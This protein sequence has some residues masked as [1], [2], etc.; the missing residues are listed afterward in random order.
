[1]EGQ[2]KNTILIK[3]KMQIV[4]PAPVAQ[5]IMTMRAV[6]SP[7]VIQT[8]S[9]SQ[10]YGLCK[11]YG[12]SARKWLREFGFLLPE[13]YR[14]RLY[15]KYRCTSIHMFAA[16]LAGMNYD[17][18]NRIL[19]LSEKLKDMPL[20]WQ[21]F[22]RFGWTKLAVVANVAHGE[23]EKFWLDKLRKMPKAA[24]IEYVRQ[25][26]NINNKNSDEIGPKS[27]LF[28]LVPCEK[29]ESEI[30]GLNK[31]QSVGT[32][33]LGNEFTDGNVAANV[34][35][36]MQRSEAV[37]F[38]G[39]TVQPFFKKLKFRVDPETEFEF[40]KFKQKMEKERKVELT[41]GETLK[42]LLKKVKELESEKFETQAMETT[43]IS[44][45]NK[46]LQNNNAKTEI[47]KPADLVKDPKSFHKTKP[48]RHI[49]NAQKRL[50]LN[51]YNGKCAFPSC[52]EPYFELHHPDRFSTNQ[53]H[54]KI[55]PLCKTHH[56]AAHAGLI[57]NEDKPVEQWELDFD[58]GTDGRSTNKNLENLI[59]PKDLNSTYIAYGKFC[60]NFTDA[61]VREYFDG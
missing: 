39:N 37:A 53:S 38:Q 40:K 32:L 48:S 33:K 58:G 25:W 35:E 15:R 26:R 9:D 29:H 55:Y 31:P 61:R 28:D 60:K 23:T 22:R 44:Q 2:N 54:E 17:V 21:E 11:E 8:L 41:M 42:A 16:K 43:K 47:Q 51:K 3:T 6:Q 50:I 12:K 59:D 5:T 36:G 56:Q 19:N 18:T 52:N 24:L 20:L 49:P 4:Q 14:R 10:L 46:N 27:N 7:R 30:L 57:K 1:M 13:V 34:Q 45:K